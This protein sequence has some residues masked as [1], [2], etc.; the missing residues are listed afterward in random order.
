MLEVYIL[1]KD[2]ERAKKWS[3]VTLQIKMY[4]I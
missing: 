3:A 2:K 4:T 1:Y